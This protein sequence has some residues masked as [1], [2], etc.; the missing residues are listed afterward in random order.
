V[1]GLI[2]ATFATDPARVA[3]MR[4]LV[5]RA[6]QR[7]QATPAALRESVAVMH[8]GDRAIAPQLAGIAA[9]FPAADAAAALPV[10]AALR[11]WLDKQREAPQD[12]RHD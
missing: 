8:I 5:W 4:D 12:G 3:G 7:E 1:P 10:L 6:W 9:A 2:A 11:H